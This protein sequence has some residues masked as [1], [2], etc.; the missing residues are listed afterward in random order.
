MGANY[1]SMT[2][3]GSM[4]R[5]EVKAHFKARQEADAYDCGHSYSGAWNMCEGLRFE[6]KHFPSY[7]AADNYV[8]ENTDKWGSALCVTFTNE[9]GES[10]WYIGGWRAE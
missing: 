9:N 3:K 6:A 2:L 8:S 1:G 4:T 7:E 10:A 5:N